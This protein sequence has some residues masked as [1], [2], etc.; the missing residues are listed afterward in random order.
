MQPT[1][2]SAIVVLNIL[3][4]RSLCMTFPI[5]VPNIVHVTEDKI[6]NTA[7]R[8]NNGKS[9]GV[10]EPEFDNCAPIIL[11]KKERLLGFII[12]NINA[13]INVNGFE[14]P[15]TICLP[16]VAIPVSYT[17]LTLPTKA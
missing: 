10:K 7:N 13:G 17:H 11:N 8:M 14:L 2:K 15:L 3:K 6:L 9:L 12:W 4:A 5:A 1:S 16:P